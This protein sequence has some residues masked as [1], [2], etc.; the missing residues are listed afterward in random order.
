MKILEIIKQK[1]A[2]PFQT[3]DWRE[4]RIGMIV[5]LIFFILVAIG[6][7]VTKTWSFDGVILG[8]FF[9]GGVIVS[10]FFNLMNPNNQKQK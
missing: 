2:E 9:G 7:L 8:Y 1:L 5:H 6:M 3:I 4:F 10:A